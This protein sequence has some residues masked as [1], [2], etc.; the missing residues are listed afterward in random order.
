ML[1]LVKKFPSEKQCIV[2]MQQPVLLLPKFWAEVFTR[3][4]GLAVK[5]S[6]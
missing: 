3:F 5:I 1:V 6:E 2:M 4:R